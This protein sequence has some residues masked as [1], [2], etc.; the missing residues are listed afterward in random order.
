MP[1]AGSDPK[2]RC[3]SSWA[4]RLHHLHG[5][6]DFARLAFRDKNVSVGRD[7]NQTGIPQSARE[8]RDVESRWNV[9]RSSPGT[10]NDL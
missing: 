5:T 9:N 10:L 2:R 3:L 8:F 7:A 6:V 1:K 4:E